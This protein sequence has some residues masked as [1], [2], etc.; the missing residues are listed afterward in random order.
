MCL[1]TSSLRG[2]ARGGWDRGGGQGGEGLIPFPHRRGR[3]LSA[4]LTCA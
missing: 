1:Q 3:A 4:C 2:A